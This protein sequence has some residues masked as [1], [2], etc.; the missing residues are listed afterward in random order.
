MAANRLAE[1]LEANADVLDI[2]KAHIMVSHRELSDKMQKV[3]TKTMEMDA[4]I[5][6]LR[7]EAKAMRANPPTVVC[8]SQ[9]EEGKTSIHIN[10][11][12]TS[13]VNMTGNDKSVPLSLEQINALISRDTSV[14]LSKNKPV[15]AIVSPADLKAFP[16]HAKDKPTP[17]WETEFHTGVNGEGGTVSPGGPRK[18]T[19]VRF[20][21]VVVYRIEYDVA[22]GFYRDK[23][24][25]DNTA[26][27][28]K[29][30]S[31]S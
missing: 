1:E 3:V 18:T 17:D 30:L 16:F 15:F 12:G 29:N 24:M 7:L 4:K 14:K 25:L 19:R 21:G 6:A 23:L 13:S 20:N 31:T 8:A 22:V 5:R 26:F 9:I 28:V 11:N 2:E 27:P 10:G